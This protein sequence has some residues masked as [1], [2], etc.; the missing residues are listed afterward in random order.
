VK[1]A[2]TA[3]ICGGLLVFVVPQAASAE[4]RGAH[5]A[6]PS[7]APSDGK[8]H[9]EA[10]KPTA[11]DSGQPKQDAPGEGRSHYDKLHHDGDSF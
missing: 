5:S 8:G 1:R 9:D 6:Q 4:E 3:M 10:S 2:L 7:A 11:E